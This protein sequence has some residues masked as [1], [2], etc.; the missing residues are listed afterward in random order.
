[1]PNGLSGV[2]PIERDVHCS[3][4]P[5]DSGNAATLRRASRFRYNSP[6][7]HDLAGGETPGAGIVALV[8]RLRPIRLQFDGSSMMPSRTPFEVARA[9]HRGVDRLDLLR[10]ELLEGSFWKKLQPEERA[11][12]DAQIVHRRAR[13]HAVVIVRKAL[14]LGEALPAAGGATLEVRFGR[15][16]AVV[17]RDDRLTGQRHLM[18]GAKTEIGQRDAIE[19]SRRRDHER[20]VGRAVLGDRYR[21]R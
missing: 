13:D 11:R 15:C 17:V 12:L 3:S 8:G 10:R 2:P 14:H 21:S 1:M 18:H 5:R 19:L 6:H 20:S 16:A 9:Q 7:R 4:P